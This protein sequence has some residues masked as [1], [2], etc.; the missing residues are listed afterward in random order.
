M[1]KTAAHT[2]SDR[3]THFPVPQQ[4]RSRER[5]CTWKRTIDDL[6]ST[7]GGCRWEE[8]E[9][10]FENISKAT[11]SLVNNYLSNHRHSRVFISH[12]MDMFANFKDKRQAR[13]NEDMV[14]S[15]LTLGFPLE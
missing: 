10:A 13:Y 3:E 7:V 2:G 15:D 12:E 5:R 8:R 14:F 9:T 4:Q 11:T 6:M 1:I